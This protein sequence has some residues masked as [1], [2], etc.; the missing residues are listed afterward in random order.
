M[1]PVDEQMKED[2]CAKNFVYVWHVLFCFMGQPKRNRETQR[3]ELS[4]N[5]M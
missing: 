4:V 1:L 5:G 2:N 3:V